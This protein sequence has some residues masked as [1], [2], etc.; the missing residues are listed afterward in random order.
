LKPKT[1]NNI[2]NNNNNNNIQDINYIENN[3]NNKI[4]TGSKKNNNKNFNVYE[5]NVMNEEVNRDKPNNLNSPNNKKI[6]TNRSEQKINDHID[7]KKL[8]DDGSSIKVLGHRKSRKIITIPKN[9]NK[10]NEIYL[11]MQKRNKYIHRKFQFCKTFKYLFCRKEN[12]KVK[13]S[14]HFDFAM[15]YLTDRLDVT[16]YI[17]TLEVIDRLRILLLNSHQNQSLDYMKKTN[18]HSSIE[19]I[20]L[21][22]DMFKDH[23]HNINELISYYNEKIESGDMEEKDLWLFEILNPLIKKAIVGKN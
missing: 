14:D 19:L 10:N 20:N 13:R 12:V 22:I 5:L 8:I 11:N 17:R 18:L 4:D 1:E 16:Y 3:N 2:N 21:D 15:N 7:E 9:L 23:G 6:A